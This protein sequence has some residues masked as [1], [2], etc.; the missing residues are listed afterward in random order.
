MQTYFFTLEVLHFP[1]RFNRSETRRK[2]DR[3]TGLSV[4]HSNDPVGFAR[5]ATHSLQSLL[6]SSNTSVE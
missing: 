6:G 4:R 1:A 3:L 2:L 5:F